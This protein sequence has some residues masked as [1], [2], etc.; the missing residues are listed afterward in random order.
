MFL[1]ITRGNPKQCRDHVNFIF[2]LPGCGKNG[3]RKETILTNLIG[4]VG[5]HLPHSFV[6][7]SLYYPLPPLFFPQA[8]GGFLMVIDIDGV[9]LYASDNMR[10]FLT[11]T[12]H[13][14]IGHSIHD[15]V[16]SETDR[17]IIRK[18]LMPE[19]MEQNL[20]SV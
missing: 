4:K 15:L 11:L 20:H 14:V 9:I 16:K 8:M 10:S 13:D 19:G 12:P 6:W 18:N 17:E 1:K 3:A 2:T 5:S 7:W